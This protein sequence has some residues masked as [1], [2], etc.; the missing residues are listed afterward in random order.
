VRPR[1]RTVLRMKRSRFRIPLLR[2]KPMRVFDHPLDTAAQIGACQ[3]AYIRVRATA[4][5]H[6]LALGCRFDHAWLRTRRDAPKGG[7]TK[8]LVTAKPVPLPPPTDT[9]RAAQ[10]WIQAKLADGT[11]SAVYGFP[12]GGRCRIG[13]Y[14]SHEQLMDLLMEYP[15]SP[16]VE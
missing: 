3:A 1:W 11:L 10:E 4:L 14:D 2:A 5:Q 15:L 16:F 6:T 7:A 13:E 8:F 12:G 9:V